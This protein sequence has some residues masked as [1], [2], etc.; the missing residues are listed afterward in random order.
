MNLHS[1][2]TRQTDL[3]LLSPFPPASGQPPD[4]FCVFLYVKAIFFYL[5]CWKGVARPGLSE[6]TAPQRTSCSG[7]SMA[8]RNILQNIRGDVSQV[9]NR[10]S[11][12]S[13]PEIA[14][15]LGHVAAPFA[16]F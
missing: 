10:R 13:L 2:V 7:D 9:S 11:Q 16:I 5:Q 8:G 15:H 3:H 1:H 14:A 12:L 6:H 4:N